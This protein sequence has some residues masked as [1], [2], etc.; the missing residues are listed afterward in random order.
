MTFGRR[1]SAQPSASSSIPVVNAGQCCGSDYFF[2]V[3][4]N[5]KKFQDLNG[6]GGVNNPE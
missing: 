3:V 1:R 2:L 6:L 5:K 4:V